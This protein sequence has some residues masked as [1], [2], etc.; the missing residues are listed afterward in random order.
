MPMLC[1][2]KHDQWLNGFWMLEALHGFIENPDG[3][4]DERQRVDEGRKDADSMVAEG[5]TSIRRFFGLSRRKPGEAKCK[6]VGEHMPRIREQ[7]Q[8]V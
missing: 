4:Q 2:Q 6:D 3:N 8:G 1:R 7:C 5:L